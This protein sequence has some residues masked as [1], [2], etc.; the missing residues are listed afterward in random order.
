NPTSLAFPPHSP[1][2]DAWQAATHFGAHDGQWLTLADQSRPTRPADALSVYLRLAASLTRETGNHAYEQ[3]V[4]LLLSIRDCH[5]HLGTPDDFTAYLTTLRAAQKRKRNL[6][7]L[8]DDHGL[9]G[10]ASG[11]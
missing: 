2:P 5:R 3:L 7:R 11:L 10:P 8:M 9:S 6:M 1:P 4:S